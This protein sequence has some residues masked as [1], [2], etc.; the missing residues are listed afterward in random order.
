MDTTEFADQRRVRQLAA[1]VGFRLWKPHGRWAWAYGPYALIDPKTNAI[2]QE[3]IDLGQ[4]EDW[5]RHQS[6]SAPPPR[7]HLPQR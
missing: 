4:A 1:S 7:R 6:P 2:V 3:Q 5:L